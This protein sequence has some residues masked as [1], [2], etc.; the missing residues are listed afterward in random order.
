M[1]RNIRKEIYVGSKKKASV[2]LH[3]GGDQKVCLDRGL[4]R[5]VQ[6]TLKWEVL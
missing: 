2:P 1:L 6:K 4:F 5:I 3:C